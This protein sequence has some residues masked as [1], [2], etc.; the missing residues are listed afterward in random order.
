MVKDLSARLRSGTAAQVGAPTITSSNAEADGSAKRILSNRSEGTT[1][2]NSAYLQT[3]VLMNMTNF[4]W[5][6]AERNNGQPVMYN[7]GG[8]HAGSPHVSI[9][10]GS[11][12][13]RG[14][15]TILAPFS[16]MHQVLLHLPTDTLQED[17][18]GLLISPI[19][20]YT[21][22]AGSPQHFAKPS[23]RS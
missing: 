11:M 19:P 17:I 15:D 2:V 21:S 20:N 14:A 5:A 3:M 12:E 6:T 23:Y 18:L 4:L 1:L 7:N 10:A 8:L 22:P 9:F 13:I 16:N